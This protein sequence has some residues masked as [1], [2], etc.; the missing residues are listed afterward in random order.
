MTR[1]RFAACVAAGAALV[2]TLVGSG[3][4]SAQAQ[5]ARPTA[6]LA[7]N[8]SGGAEEEAFVY[9]AGA[10]AD[11]LVRLSNGGVPGGPVTWEPFPHTV[12]GSYRPVAGNFGGDE[13]DEIFWY[14]PGTA[15][16]FVWTFT[17][18]TTVTSR[19]YTVDGNFRPV[20]DDFDGN[21]YDDVLWYAPG[22]ARDF[23]WFFNADGSF[24]SREYSIVGNFQPV[25]GTFGADAIGDVFW[26]AAGSATDY[27]WE[28]R[29]DGT[30]RSTPF[31]VNGTYRPFKVDIFGD[32]TGGEDIFFYAPGLAADSVWD[33]LGGQLL[34]VIPQPVNG[35][36]VP[37]A[38]TLLS[39]ACSDILW[40]EPGSTGLWDYA[41]T[42][43]GFQRYDYLFPEIA[44]AGSA[45]AASAGVEAA[46]GPQL[47]R[48]R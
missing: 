4:P 36:Y 31:Q 3:A 22:T 28:F 12:S 21:G 27:M 5:Q 40:F 41:C 45:D 48:P 46:R 26:H 43:G 1:R 9:R 42:G 23:L 10:G 8:F 47:N 24:V 2:A 44:S 37:A 16:D 34:L 6:A 19:E 7:G 15:R 17:S 11:A 14:A 39:D 13:H 20:A 38:G 32:G 18:D 29:A 30:Y 25:A 35:D 33:F